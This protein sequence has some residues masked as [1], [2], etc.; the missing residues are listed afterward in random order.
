[1]FYWCSGSIRKCDYHQEV[2]LIMVI[3]ILPMP[4]KVPGIADE[5]EKHFGGFKAPP[6]ATNRS[7]QLETL[8]W[9]AVWAWCNVQ[10]S[11]WLRW[12][13]LL[14]STYKIQ[15]KCF[16]VWLAGHKNATQWPLLRCVCK[17]AIKTT[18][19]PTGDS[20][21]SFMKP[22][23]LSWIFAPTAF[24]WVPKG[25]VKEELHFLYGL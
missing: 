1:M 23:V 17:I 7:L 19:H 4:L 9:M 3:V 18:V 10:W 25:G 12:M 20:P 11:S 8:D 24:F 14:S 5:V 21:L 2:F 6:V 15:E 16:C 13:T 22:W